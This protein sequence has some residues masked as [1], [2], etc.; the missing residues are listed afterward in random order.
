MARAW[1]LVLGLLFLCVIIAT[2]MTNGSFVALRSQDVNESSPRAL[3]N[4]GQK[5]RIRNIVYESEL[6]TRI[7]H[8]SPNAI[9]HRALVI[10]QE[11]INLHN[12][13]ERSDVITLLSEIVKGGRPRDAIAA[14]AYVI[15]LE[16]KLISAVTFADWS[17]DSFDSPRGDGLPTRRE[18][19][20]T[21]VDEILRKVKEK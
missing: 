19:L 9:P 13:Q 11:L 12:N 2:E 14:G 15:A 10:P 1:L 16:E 3:L 20:S 17:E 7:V 21:W 8:D 6:A 4:S 18:R 5:A